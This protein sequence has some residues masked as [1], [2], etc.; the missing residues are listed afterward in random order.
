VHG[1][2]VAHGEVIEVQRVV[3][4]ARGFVGPKDWSA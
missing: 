1:G 2:V 3:W 4:C